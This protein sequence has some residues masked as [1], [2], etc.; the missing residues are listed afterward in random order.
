M[1][2]GGKFKVSVYL[3]FGQQLNFATHL[4]SAAGG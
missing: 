2:F 4:P 1:P 3:F